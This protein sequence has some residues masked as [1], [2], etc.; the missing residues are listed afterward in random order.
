MTER[1]G[2]LLREI[3]AVPF[4]GLLA[5][6]CLMGS[7]VAQTAPSDGATS[8]SI[9]V[10][11]SK[12]AFVDFDRI[13]AGSSAVGAVFS[14]LTARMESHAG[15][16]DEARREIDDMR[17]SIELQGPLLTEEARAARWNALMERADIADRDA[18]DY[19]RQLDSCRGELD[20]LTNRITDAVGAVA[21]REGI[22]I[23]LR[24]ENVIYGS[25]AADM[26]PLVIAHLDASS[27]APLELSDPAARSDAP[28]QL[29]SE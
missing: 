24:G 8:P 3:G 16:L 1:P 15:A 12:V 5:G 6:V 23:V 29:A 10:P 19:E 11:V 7:A 27:S 17:G 13:V 4:I 25:D 2:R 14:D 21:D 28:A 9:G 20:A 26:T 18:A 22:A